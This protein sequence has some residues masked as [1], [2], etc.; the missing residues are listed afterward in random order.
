MK[1]SAFLVLACVAVSACQTA[2]GL[3]TPG[4]DADCPT[5]T[6]CE[7]PDTD[8]ALPPRQDTV[9][10]VSYATWHP[11]KPGCPSTLTVMNLRHRIAFDA[12]RPEAEAPDQPE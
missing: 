2:G 4:L 7:D 6:L 5:P 12:V 1:R 10:M 9:A 8:A 11:L 3:A